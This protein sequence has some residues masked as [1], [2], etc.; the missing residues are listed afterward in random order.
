ML[1]NEIKKK[2]SQ[3]NLGYF[4]KPESWDLRNPIEKKIK[5]NYKPRFLVNSILNDLIEKK[6]IR[7]E[8]KIRVKQG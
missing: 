8:Q 3:V 6:S 1:K 7:K 2:K 5:T 4:S